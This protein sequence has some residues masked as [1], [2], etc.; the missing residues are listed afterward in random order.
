MTVSEL[1]EQ[2]KT[3]PCDMI[4]RCMYDFIDSRWFT[5]F[6]R[7]LFGITVVG[8]LIHIWQNESVTLELTKTQVNYL[9]DLVCENIKS[10]EYWGDHKQFMKMQ[11]GVLKKIE[12]AY[13]KP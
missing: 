8:S 13:D 9:Y 10:G 11:N 5:Y 3:Y 1:I 6:C 12:E 7:L 4:E 2:L